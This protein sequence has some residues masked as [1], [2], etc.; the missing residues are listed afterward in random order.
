[1][2]KGSFKSAR[3]SGATKI[4]HDKKKVKLSKYEDEEKILNLIECLESG[5]IAVVKNYLKSKLRPKR[6]NKTKKTLDIAKEFRRDLIIKQT[7]AEKEAKRVLKELKYRFAFQKEFFYS[8]GKFYI[9]DFYLPLERIVIEIDGG[10]H[11][12]VEQLEKDKI[13]TANIEKKNIKV[14]RF[15]NEVVL[16]TDFKPILIKEI[17]KNKLT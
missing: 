9:L 3:N 8:R 1:M 2:S 12:T 17:E 13:R 16:N 4:K 7:P 6:S 11:N 15:T 5:N 10:Y 14:I